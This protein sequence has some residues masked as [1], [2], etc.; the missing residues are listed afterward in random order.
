M[1]QVTN[2]ISYS[3][4]LNWSEQPMHV[5]LDDTDVG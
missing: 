4:Q 1:R 3:N 5:C 2:M